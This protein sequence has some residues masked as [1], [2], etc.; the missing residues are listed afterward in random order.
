MYEVSLNS[1][2]YKIAGVRCLN[3]QQVELAV[4]SRYVF[5][6]VGIGSSDGGHRIIRSL[7]DQ[8]VAV[9]VLKSVQAD[10]ISL[11]H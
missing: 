10:A 1:S 11:M 4:C 2:N 8:T 6:Y 5:F 9:T 7:T 3:S